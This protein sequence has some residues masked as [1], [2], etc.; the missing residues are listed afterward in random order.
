MYWKKERMEKE[1]RYP[2]VKEGEQSRQFLDASFSGGIEPFR[3]LFQSRS[4]SILIHGWESDLCDP[5]PEDFLLLFLPFPPCFLKLRHQQLDFARFQEVIESPELHCLD[6][7]LHGRMAG[8]NDDL[9]QRIPP[10]DF[11]QGLDAVHPAFSHSR[12]TTSVFFR[13]RR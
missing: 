11:P 5:R 2:K 3:E 10:L 12:T 9:D 4:A 8:Q 7:R 6:G 13:S 1:G